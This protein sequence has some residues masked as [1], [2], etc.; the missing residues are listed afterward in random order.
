[1]ASLP[2][3]PGGGYT[4]I[5]VCVFVLSL[6]V[7]FAVKEFRF[8]FHRRRGIE[9][10]R[11]GNY[12]NAMLH[13][14]QAERLWMLRLSKQ[15]MSSSAEDCRNLEEILE[16]IS[17]ASGHCSLAIDASAYRKA[18]IDMEQ[19]FSNYRGSSRD[20][21]KIYSN[22]T[23]HQKQFRAEIKRFLA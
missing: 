6:V 23:R 16:L 20:Y 15:T 22:F 1:M 10:F 14:I 17:E 12:K 18:T 11:K 4:V 21:P 7:I 19:Y 2:D 8:S 3:L 5:I 13:L 9:Y